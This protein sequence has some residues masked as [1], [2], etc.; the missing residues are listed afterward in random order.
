MSPSGGAADGARRVE[1]IGSVQQKT[2]PRTQHT[3]F[4]CSF[5]ACLLH[6]NRPSPEKLD[7]AHIGGLAEWERRRSDAGW[8]V[9]SD[10]SLARGHWQARELACRD[11]PEPHVRGF[12]SEPSVRPA[13]FGAI[14]SGDH[15]FQSARNTCPHHE[16]APVHRAGART[17]FCCGCNLIIYKFS[18]GGATPRGGSPNFIAPRTRAPPRP[19]PAPMS[20]A[21]RT[22]TVR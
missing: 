8:M 2:Q 4:A 22:P 10:G 1:R 19:P 18:N 14:S 5:A 21:A 11:S 20:P 9:R 16:K 6:H 12:A 13:T 3:P 7:G 17:I 15:A